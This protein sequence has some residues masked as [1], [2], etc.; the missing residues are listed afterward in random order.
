MLMT[1]KRISRSAMNVTKSKILL[2]RVDVSDT[3]PDID[4]ALAHIA[5]ELKKDEYGNRMSHQKKVALLSR[6][7]ML[8]DARLERLTK[9]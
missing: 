7:D 8:L 6:I 5:V 4:E 1:L 3:V 2:M 9:N